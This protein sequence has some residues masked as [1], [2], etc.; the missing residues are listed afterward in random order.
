[1]PAPCTR[2]LSPNICALV[3]RGRVLQQLLDLESVPPLQNET[4]RET[5]EMC[6]ESVVTAPARANGSRFTLHT[7]L[8]ETLRASSDFRIKKPVL[9]LCRVGITLQCHPIVLMCNTII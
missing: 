3:Q 4:G 8:E 7:E 5:E 9:E 6:V 1:M 2:K